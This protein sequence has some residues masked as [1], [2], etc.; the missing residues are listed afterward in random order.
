MPA[1]QRGVL[2]E[3]EGAGAHVLG[4]GEGVGSQ[5]AGAEASQ[6]GTGASEL[7]LQ[8]RGGG[9]YPPCRG[10]LVGDEVTA[11]AREG[12]AVLEEAREGGDGSAED[13]VVGCSVGGLLAGELGAG[14]EDGEV[15]EAE[16]A[17]GEGEE[18]GALADGLDEGEVS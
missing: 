10:P 4:E 13:Q 15:G 9:A 18:V 7:L 5:Q 2:D 14:V 11:G 6:E 17:G 8:V 16:F 1:L 12:E 3:H